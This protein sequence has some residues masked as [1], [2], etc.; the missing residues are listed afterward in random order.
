MFITLSKLL[1]STLSLSTVFLGLLFFSMSQ[2]HA[3]GTLAGTIIGTTAQATFDPIGSSDTLTIVSSEAGNDDLESTG[4]VTTFYV[5][6]RIDFIVTANASSIKVS[7]ANTSRTMT[8]VLT[9]EGNSTRNFRFDTDARDANIAPVTGSTNS[10]GFFKLLNTTALATVV[11]NQ[12]PYTNLAPDGSTTITLRFDIPKVSSDHDAGVDYS[13]G[14]VRL[15]VRPTNSTLAATMGTVMTTDS[16][17]SAFSTGVRQYV[18]AEGQSSPTMVD[19]STSASETD[20]EGSIVVT[21]GSS[22]TN[23]Y[24][25]RNA[26]VANNNSSYTDGKEDGVYA[27]QVYAQIRPQPV[28]KLT[29]TVKVVC[30]YI[31]GTNNPKAIPGAIVRHTITLTNSGYG[32]ATLNNINDSVDKDILR[33][34]HR[35]IDTSNANL[36]CDQYVSDS[37]ASGV[38]FALTCQQSAANARVEDTVSAGSNASRCITASPTTVYMTTGGGGAITASSNVGSIVFNFNNAAKRVN[39]T[40]HFGLLQNTAGSSP[41]MSTYN[42]TIPALSTMIISYDAQF[43]IDVHDSTSG[44]GDLSK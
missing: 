15:F 43:H 5:D 39:N 27:V 4:S 31:N 19:A 41:G 2:A 34:Q 13:K 26:T 18:F 9:N 20:S 38:S 22:A 40:D 30:D 25:A 35:M 29:K 37:V 36:S 10:N 32:P 6:E 1:R 21:G 3:A 8:F 42:R 28:V 7:P 17:G 24:L 16:S 33:L 11:S 14:Y 23:P 44:V 12:V